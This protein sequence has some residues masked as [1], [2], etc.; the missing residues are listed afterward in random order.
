MLAL[1]LMSAIGTR[2]FAQ[3]ANSIFLHVPIAADDPTGP[4]P[5]PPPPDPGF[6]LHF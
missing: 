2:T 3:H 4:N 5:L 6:A 1:F